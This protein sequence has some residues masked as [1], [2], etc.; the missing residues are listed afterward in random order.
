[1]ISNLSGVIDYLCVNKVAFSIGDF[2]I[3]WYGIIICAGIFVAIFVAMIYAKKKGYSKDLPLDIALVVLP[4]GII[5]ARLFS[6]LFESSLSISDF[7]NFRTGGLSIMGA[8][9]FGGLALL[10]FVLIKKDDNKFKYF[11]TLCVVLILA[12][13]IGRWG[14]YFNGE[15]Y[16]QVIDSSSFF[17]R[18]PFAVEI[19]GV[20]YQALFFWESMLDLYGFYIL[21]TVY[22]CVK[23]SGYVTAIYLIYYGVV[24]TVLE[25][26]R[27][28]EFVLKLGNIPVS[29]VCSV[30]MIVVGIVIFVLL[31]V[32]VN[33]KKE[34]KTSG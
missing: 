12:Q 23:K 15:L 10:V 25:S 17:A 11:D 26:F 19:D 29:Q 5:G 31:S 3:Y 33:N 30:A 18:F 16:G 1:M 27:D 8:I 24:R 2:P 34:V 7:F 14:N 20:Y 4:F 21:S 13:A 28:S 9:I 6:V 32:K 22:L